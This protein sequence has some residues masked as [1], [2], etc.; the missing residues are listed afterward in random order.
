MYRI[1]LIENYILLYDLL[2]KK[3]SRMKL[4]KLCLMNIF[5]HVHNITLNNLQRYSIEEKSII[6]LPTF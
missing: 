2:I 6:Y 1:F 4:F 5:S 3:V